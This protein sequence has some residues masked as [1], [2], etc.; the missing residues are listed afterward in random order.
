[1]FR[2]FRQS[3]CEHGLRWQQAAVV[4]LALAAGL[5]YSGHFLANRA[6]AHDTARIFNLFR[7]NL[8]S[9]NFFGEVQWWDP[10]APTGFPVYYF[11]ILGHNCATPLFVAAGFLAWIMGLAGIHLH[12]Y[13]ELYIVY[14][15]IIAPLLFSLG[16]LLLARQVLSGGRPLALA[17]VLA[18]FSPAVVMNLTNPWVVEQAA[19]GIFF[20][21][22]WLNHLRRPGKRSFLVLLLSVLLLGVSLNHLFLF[23][24]VYFV[25]LFVLAVRLFPGE[26]EAGI[27]KA[28]AA[29]PRAWRLAAVALAVLSILPGAVTYFQGS[30]IYRS[31]LGR[32]TYEYRQLRPGNP[33]EVVAVSTPGVGFQWMREGDPDYASP[34]ARWLP[35][36]GN[37]LE[38]SYGYMGVLCLPLVFLGLAFGRPPWRNRLLFLI[39]AVS[40]VVLLSGYSP[41]FGSVLALPGPLRAV[42]HFGDT[43]FRAGLFFLLI[44]AA[45]LGA[46]RLLEGKRFHRRIFA[47]SFAIS[48]LFSVALF[49][50]V[51]GL[52]PG[53]MSPA[54]QP[55]FGL[56]LIMIFLFA[57]V[58]SRLSF[59]GS[60][61]RR[62]Q[63]FTALLLLTL[64]DVS[65]ASFLHVR[66]CIWEIEKSYE[67]NP[68]DKMGPGY[69]D[70]RIFTDSLMEMRGVKDLK[71]RGFDPAA[72]PKVA[73]STSARSDTAGP[74]PRSV[75]PLELAYIELPEQFSKNPAFARFFDAGPGPS[76]GKVTDFRMSYNSFVIQSETERQALFFLGDAYSPYWKARVN[77]EPVVI[78]PAFGAFKAVPVPAGRSRVEFA[79]SPPVLPFALVAAYLAIILVVVSAALP[80]PPK[81][82]S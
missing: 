79:F 61:P 2:F 48:A 76:A 54:L 33:L 21:A 71:D 9:L 8:H 26:G 23:W 20:A 47:L 27:R 82:S 25:P 46:E 42:N 36:S 37:K 7:D 34:N 43:P 12:S 58:I 78:A 4:V 69:R 29:A 30:D 11:S 10:L 13:I 44:L 57:V 31:G 50:A 32:R 14:F 40:G 6:L 22:A 65:S 53:G 63:L 39:A 62:R 38:K 60:E 68:V 19:F 55:V 64:V 73:F 67:N 1:V 66:E 18:A 28:V 5:M 16:F 41:L 45:G 56:L 80:F 77:G 15:G 81:Q 24:N 17:L 74:P 49:I 51:S 75:N 70:L 72:F 35:V 3:R 59:T 52:P